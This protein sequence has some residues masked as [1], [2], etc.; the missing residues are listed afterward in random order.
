MIKI[1]IEDVYFIGKLEKI[2]SI[3][4]NNICIMKQF[5][6]EIKLDKNGYE[7]YCIDMYLLDH[8]YYKFVGSI[9]TYSD[10]VEINF[11]WRC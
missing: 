4:H 5:C 8:K 10:D 3:I 1:Q 7:I 11:V 6:S 9:Y 2:I